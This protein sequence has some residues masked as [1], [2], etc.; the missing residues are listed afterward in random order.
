M[1]RSPALADYVPRASWM[2]TPSAYDEEEAEARSARLAGAEVRV[3]QATG[4]TAQE[5]ATPRSQ[6]LRITSEEALV[7]GESTV[8]VMMWLL[9]ARRGKPHTCVF[10]Y[11]NLLVLVLL[12]FWCAFATHRCLYAP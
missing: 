11:C 5:P 8:N 10:S 4:S 3:S 2:V 1:E 7:I 9:P 6:L 12:Y